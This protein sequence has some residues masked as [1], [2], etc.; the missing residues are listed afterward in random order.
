[1]YFIT[2]MYKFIYVITTSAITVISLVSSIKVDCKVHESK[3]QKLSTPNHFPTNYRCLF[4]SIAL[5]QH[6]SQRPCHYLAINHHYLSTG[7]YRPIAF[8]PP[9]CKKP[10]TSRNSN[11]CRPISLAPEPKRSRREVY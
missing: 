9:V 1:M 8:L 11:N 10:N 5:K 7:N 6:K 3:K 4:I 2:I